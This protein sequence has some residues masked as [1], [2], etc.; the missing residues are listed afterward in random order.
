MVRLT[1][2]HSE[3]VSCK[4][5]PFGLLCVI[6]V[7]MACF[8]RPSHAQSGIGVGFVYAAPHAGGISVR[9]KAMQVLVPEIR[10][11]NGGLFVGVAVRYNHSVRDWKRVKFKVFGQ[12]GRLSSREES[13]L[14]ARYRFT[15]GGSAELRVG[16]KSSPK[17]LFLTL[18]IG[19][20]VDHL[21]ELGSAP[22]RGVG[23][24]AFF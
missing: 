24:H 4:C 9:H 12:I 2:N 20:S 8:I 3:R 17:G 22:A 21:G 23:I 16:R 13:D 10:G 7:G 19:L 14:E 11:N 5:V 1:D 18:N 15:A 6:I